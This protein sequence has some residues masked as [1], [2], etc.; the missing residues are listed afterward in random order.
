VEFVQYLDET[1]EKI[2]ES[3]IYIESL[4]QEVPVQ[5]AMNYNSSYTENVVSYVNTI[6]T[7]EGG[8]HVTGFRRALTRTLKSYAD[9]SG[10]LE[11]LKIEVSG[12]DFR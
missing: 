3:P 4:N 7:Y 11:K 2:I 9:M 5:V 6:N 12:D 10:M 8:S 1:R